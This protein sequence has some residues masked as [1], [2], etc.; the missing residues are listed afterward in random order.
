MRIETP[1]LEQPWWA[2]VQG[3]LAVVG[4]VAIIVAVVDFILRHSES[5][6][7]A[8]SFTLDRSGVVENGV[9]KITVTV[10]PMGPHLLYEPEIRVWGYTAFDTPALPP[11]LSAHDDAVEIEMTVPKDKLAETWIG[12]VWVVPKRWAPHAAGSRIQVIPNPDYQSWMLY[13]WRFWPR[14]LSGRWVTIG[15]KKRGLMHIP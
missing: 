9:T 5:A 4:I 1:W 13:K 6:P 10:R 2:G 14:L 7:R 8:M 15:E 11:V 3:L 12:V